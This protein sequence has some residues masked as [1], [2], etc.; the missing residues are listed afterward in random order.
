MSD[1][2]EA[3]TKMG[4]NKKRKMLPAIF[5][6]R[7]G[8]PERG[9]L[10]TSA[11]DALPFTSRGDVCRSKKLLWLSEATAANWLRR[12]LFETGQLIVTTEDGLS[13]VC[14]AGIGDPG[15]LFVESVPRDMVVPTLD[16]DLP[17]CVCSLPQAEAILRRIYRGEHSDRLVASLNRLAEIRRKRRVEANRRLQAA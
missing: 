6:N 2:G 5:L 4:T 11:S 1:P 8:E 17:G 13:R 9:S 15:E 14:F 3:R 10:P 7:E 12:A 16:S